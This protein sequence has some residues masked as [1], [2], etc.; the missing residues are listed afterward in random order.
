MDDYV[1]EVESK[2]DSILKT[3]GWTKEDLITPNFKK[4]ER[5]HHSEDIPNDGPIGLPVEK[6]PGAIRFKVEYSDDVKDDIGWNIKHVGDEEL[7]NVKLSKHKKKDLGPL[8]NSIAKD[9]RK[10]RNAVYDDEEGAIISS[11]SDLRA[12]DDEITKKL[13]RK[14]KQR[15]GKSLSATDFNREIIRVCMD[16]N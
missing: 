12:K 14:N 3:F 7:V 6:C 10:K 9:I 8:L 11:D 1:E 4:R 2:L 16:D 13:K 15:H 5:P